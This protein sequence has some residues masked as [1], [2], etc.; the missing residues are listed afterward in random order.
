MKL[1]LIRHG[2]TIE[3][4][5]GIFQG[6]MPGKLSEEGKEQA[7]K[8]ALRLKD[9]KIDVI[10][11]SDLAR[12]ADTAN[13]IK[14]YHDA[15]IILTK[16][17]REFDIGSLS[18]KHR[19]E[20]AHIDWKN[21]PPEGSETEEH[22]KKRLIRVLDKI[23]KEHP[24]STVVFVSHGSIGRQLIGHIINKPVEEVDNLRN[25]SVSIFE[26]TGDKNHKVHVINSLEHLK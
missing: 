6:H 8:V 11:S 22:A 3:N 16:D 10:Y 17:L 23:Y 4:Q 2:E 15:P 21:N 13:I 20:V 5:Q 14:K 25:T 24:N 12:A 18:G 26:I 7:E 9:E 19:D 1:F